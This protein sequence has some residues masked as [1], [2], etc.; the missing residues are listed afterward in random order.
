MP[1]KSPAQEKLMR[2]VAHSDEFAAKVDIPRSVGREFHEADKKKKA[3]K[4]AQQYDLPKSSR[5]KMKGY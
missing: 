5:M 1:S 2:A 4:K 3:G